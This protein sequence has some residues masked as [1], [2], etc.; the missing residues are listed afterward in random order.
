M[1]TGGN[2]PVPNK[3]TLTSETT[4]T[5]KP[6]KKPTKKPAAPAPKGKKK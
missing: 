5:K 1:A 6:A 2:V 4:A 3:T